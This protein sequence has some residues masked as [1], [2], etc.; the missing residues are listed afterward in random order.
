MCL[1]K[2]FCYPSHCTLHRGHERHRKFAI[3]LRS[4]KKFSREEGRPIVYLDKI[5]LN[6]HVATGEWVS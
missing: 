3:Y 1:N 5:W 2:S 4:I 6:N